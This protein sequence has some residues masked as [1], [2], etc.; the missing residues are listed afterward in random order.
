MWD[1][2]MLWGSVLNDQVWRDGETL[3][4]SVCQFPQG[5]TSITAN[6]SLLI[7]HYP[8]EGRW[9]HKCPQLVLWSPWGSVQP[10]DRAGA[11]QMGWSPKKGYPGLTCLANPRISYWAGSNSVLLSFKSRVFIRTGGLTEIHQ[12]NGEKM[13]PRRKAFLDVK[14][15]K[16]PSLGSFFF[17]LNKCSIRA[18]DSSWNIY[19]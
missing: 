2:A 13:S 3:I 11:G 5:E 19:F 4:C 15:K 17:F 6:F 16:K 7:S 8:H 14:K 1:R 9:A 12:K 10:L 18:I